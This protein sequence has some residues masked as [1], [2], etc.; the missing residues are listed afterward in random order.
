MGFLLL[1]AY[2]INMYLHIGVSEEYPLSRALPWALLGSYLI[3]YACLLDLYIDIED[4]MY[5]IIGEDSK[6]PILTE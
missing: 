3:V 4:L 6:D 1:L 2:K 5:G